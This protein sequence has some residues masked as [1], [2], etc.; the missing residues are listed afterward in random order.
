MADI[1]GR[2]SDRGDDFVLLFRHSVTYSLGALAQ[3]L[4]GGR[5]QMPEIARTGGPWQPPGYRG[6]ATLAILT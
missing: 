4:R 6:I 3:Q 2:E 5:V 1:A